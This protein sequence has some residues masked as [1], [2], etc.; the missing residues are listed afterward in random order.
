MC[1]VRRIGLHPGSTDPPP[2]VGIWY[3][4]DGGGVGSA[5]AVPAAPATMAAAAAAKLVGAQITIIRTES[6][7]VEARKRGLDRLDELPGIVS[8][9]IVGQH[10][11][12]VSSQLVNEDGNESRISPG[13]EQVSTAA[14]R[15]TTHRLILAGVGAHRFSREEQDA[16]ELPRLVRCHCN[17][18]VGFV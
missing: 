9:L 3:P 12:P 5:P 13:R 7:F 11:R 18:G 15:R 6:E 14:V 4:G 10:L 16:R 1:A 2:G 8:H 17:I